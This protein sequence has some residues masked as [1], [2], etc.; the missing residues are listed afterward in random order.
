MDDIVEVEVNAGEGKVG[1]MVFMRK[2]RTRH[3]EAETGWRENYA[4]GLDDIKHLNGEQWPQD[5]LEERKGRPCLTLNRL[6][7]FIDQVVG[8]QRQ[9]RSRIQVEPVDSD[10]DPE[11]AK[12]N[13]GL[14]R[15]IENMSD[16]ES[17]Y[18]WAS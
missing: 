1:E 6:P 10:G 11:I 4:L 17:A 7:G 16:A 8:D 13:E 2:V 5:I 15:N 12:I 14:I 18:D 9:N 3:N